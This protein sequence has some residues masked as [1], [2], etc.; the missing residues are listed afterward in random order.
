M[1]FGEVLHCQCLDF[2]LLIKH[3][4]DCMAV[5]IWFRVFTAPPVNV[6]ESFGKK[7]KFSVLAGGRCPPA[8]PVFGWRGNAPQ[9]PPPLSDRLQHLIE[10]AKR[11]RLDQ[12]IFFSPPLTTLAPP[13]TRAAPTTRANIAFGTLFSQYSL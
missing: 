7:Q 3:S 9:D 11:G 5:Y 6:I 4:E 2:I 8:P 1:N 13:T 10:A 12:M